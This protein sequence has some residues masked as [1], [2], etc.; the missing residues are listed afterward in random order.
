[1]LPR[2]LLAPSGKAGK[3]SPGTAGLHG[4]LVLAP[5]K[6]L[7]LS[8]PSSGHWELLPV[9]QHPFIASLTVWLMYY[10]SLLKEP[11]SLSTG[12]DISS[13]FKQ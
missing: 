11:H 2:V 10:M 8:P 6:G 12:G 3:G 13:S 5:P 7:P 9:L 1:M 4:N